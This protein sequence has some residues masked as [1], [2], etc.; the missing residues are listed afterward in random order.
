M[1][2]SGFWRR[3]M[4]SWIDGASIPPNSPHATE[5]EMKKKGVMS[6]GLLEV[7]TRP[8]RGGGGGVF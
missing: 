8:E 5:Y 3:L 1:S 2:G 6:M 4:D 7:M